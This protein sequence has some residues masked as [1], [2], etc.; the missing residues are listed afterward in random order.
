MCNGLCDV[1]R[2][3]YHWLHIYNCANNNT[4]GIYYHRLRIEWILIIII[5]DNI[6]YLEYFY[7]YYWYQN[8][9]NIIL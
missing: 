9:I 3:Y 1:S 8:K 2:L 6:E 4:F 5:K 7:F